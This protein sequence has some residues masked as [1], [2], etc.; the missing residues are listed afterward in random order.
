MNKLSSNK[1]KFIIKQIIKENVRA[2]SASFDAATTKIG[3]NKM[4]VDPTGIETLVDSQVEEVAETT[5]NLFDKIKPEFIDGIKSETA[6]LIK[7]IIKDVFR[8]AVSNAQTDPYPETFDIYKHEKLI[9]TITNQIA[10]Y[11]PFGYTDSNP[12][13]VKADKL[14][15]SK[16][17]PKIMNQSVDIN[18]NIR[19][20]NSNDYIENITESLAK[21]IFN[22]INA[23]LPGSLRTNIIASFYKN[24]G[25]NQS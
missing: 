3:P 25:I 10:L 1:L 19:Q 17:E 7:V 6:T 16:I 24:L 11:S 13:T 20:W 14:I 22:I 4:S 21:Y 5:K 12:T 15:R 18:W 23:N 8:A 2:L 9:D